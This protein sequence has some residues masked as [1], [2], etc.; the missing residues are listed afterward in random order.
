MSNISDLKDALI[1]EANDL[2]DALEKLEVLSDIDD[3]YNVRVALAAL[4][5]QGIL[6]YSIG[7]RSVTRRQVPELQAEE[8]RLYGQIKAKIRCQGIAFIDQR[9]PI[10]GGI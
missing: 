4:S 8:Q 3:W 7:G 1:D 9:Y 10:D 5:T 2:E 6:S